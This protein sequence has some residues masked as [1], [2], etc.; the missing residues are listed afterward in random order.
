MHMF[1]LRIKRIKVY[2]KMEYPVNTT[3]NEEK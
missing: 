1:K 2:S 3:P